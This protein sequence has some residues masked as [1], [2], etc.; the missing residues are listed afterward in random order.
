MKH[1]IKLLLLGLS[2]LCTSACNNYDD[3]EFVGVVVD[4]L[5]CQSMYDVGYVVHIISPDTIG[6]DYMTRDDTI[7]H[8]AVIAYRSDRLL[9]AKDKIGGRFFFDPKYSR[10]ECYYHFDHNV[11]EVVFTKLKKL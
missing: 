2:C 11:P 3:I 5:E 1:K 8:N 9:H 4:Y 7:C 10:S 6:A